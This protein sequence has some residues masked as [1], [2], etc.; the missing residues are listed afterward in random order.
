MEDSEETEIEEDAEAE[1]GEDVEEN[2]VE[3]DPD[4]R[5]EEIANN[6][7]QVEL[8]WNPEESQATAAMKSQNEDSGNE[9]KTSSKTFWTIVGSLSTLLIVLAVSLSFQVF[10]QLGRTIMA[11]AIGG[12][13]GSIINQF[14]FI[15]GSVREN[16]PRRDD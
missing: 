6:G 13:L 8:V 12:I 11:G 1:T 4:N 2:E 10:P 16:H 14:L 7:I 9:R 5:L 15:S 3:T